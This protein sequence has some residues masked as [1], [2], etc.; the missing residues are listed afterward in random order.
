MAWLGFETILAPTTTEVAQPLHYRYH[1][2]A[3]QQISMS[4]AL[5]AKQVPIK[6]GFSDGVLNTGIWESSTGATE[7]GDAL[8]LA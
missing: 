1:L 5:T 2:G 8:E 3:A 4:W 6:D 7:T